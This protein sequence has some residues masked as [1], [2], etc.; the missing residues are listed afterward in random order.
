MKITRAYTIDRQTLEILKRETN[1]SQYVCR[2]VKRLHSNA[3][4]LR[5]YEVPV[6]EL[7][8]HVMGRGGCP[9]HIEAVI[10]EYYQ[11]HK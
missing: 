1:K 2:A 10:R 5:L 4:E 9:P 11:I 3:A 7:L 6:G 8:Q